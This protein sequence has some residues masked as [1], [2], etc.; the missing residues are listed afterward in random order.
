MIKKIGILTSGGDSPGMNSVIKSIFYYSNKNKIKTYGIINGYKGLYFNKIKKIKK[1]N[2]NNIIDKGGTLLGSSRFEKLKEKKIRLKII[3]NI[4]NKIDLLIVI[5]GEGS[6]KGA[7]KLNKMNLPCITIPATI[8]N[9]INGTDYTIGFY[10]ALE[11][12][13]NYIDNLKYTLISHNRILILEVMGRKCKDLALNA[14]ICNDNLYLITKKNINKNKLLNYIK[15]NIKYN[16]YIII[17]IME[18]LIN[19]KKFSKKIENITKIETRFTS[20]GY[21]QRGSKPSAFDRILGFKMGQ[22]VV[23]KLIKKNI[24]GKCIGIKN[25]KIIQYNLEKNNI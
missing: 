6:Y 11:T 8:D 5:G 12:I 7:Y 21:I 24:T 23:K 17:I 16:K 20:L 1:K 9:D 18:N 22:F 4:K 10:T 19:I 3:D 25:N 14:S 13:V 15:K 2:I